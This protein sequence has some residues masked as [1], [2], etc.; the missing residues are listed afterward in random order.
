MIFSLQKTVSTCC[1]LLVVS[2][3]LFTESGDK[4][5]DVLKYG[6]E[7]EIVELIN[8][9]EQRDDHSLNGEIEDLFSSTR[10]SAVRESIL[11]FYGSQQ[12]SA[13]A[14]YCIEVLEDPYIHRNSTV[15]AVFQYVQKV[16]IRE[17]APLVRSLLSNESEEFRDQAIRTLGKIG[18][19]ED[20]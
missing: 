7:N 18:T 10:S 16:P 1:I 3:F 2:S 15:S 8:N 14:E 4:R 20:S 12:N 13:F 19:E 9:L 6:L 5:K 11:S 17:A